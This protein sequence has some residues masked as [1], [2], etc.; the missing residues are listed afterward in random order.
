MKKTAIMLLILT[1]VQIVTTIYLG[2]VG[3]SALLAG[4]AKCWWILL[5]AAMHVLLVAILGFTAWLVGS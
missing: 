3:F 4:D 2:Y 5:D 1:G